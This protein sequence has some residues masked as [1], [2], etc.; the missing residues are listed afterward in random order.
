M[1]RGRGKAPAPVC[2]VIGIGAARAA[3]DGRF[4]HSDVTRATIRLATPRSSSH[5]AGARSDCHE[6]NRPP[7]VGPDECNGNAGVVRPG[8]RR[9]GGGYCSCPESAPTRPSTSR[10]TELH[11][12]SMTSC[13]RTTTP[14]K[15]RSALLASPRPPAEARSSAAGGRGG[16]G[17][18]RLSIFRIVVDP[19]RAVGT[20]QPPDKH[21]YAN[22]RTSR[23]ASGMESSAGVKDSAICETS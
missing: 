14:P 23:R 10:R 3:A 5:R 2:G 18:Q 1:Q 16:Q 13:S 15:R 9:Q 4:A 20:R 7:G 21:R 12:T 19:A 22:S 17:T 8:H 11:R 6:G